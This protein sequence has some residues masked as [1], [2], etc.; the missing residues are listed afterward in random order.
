MNN[1]ELDFLLD[2]ECCPFCCQ[3][4][5]HKKNIDETFIYKNHKIVIPNYCIFECSFCKEAIV[6]QKSIRETEKILKEFREK[7]T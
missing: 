4:H 1:E 7:R 2:G 6:S 5:L 3:G